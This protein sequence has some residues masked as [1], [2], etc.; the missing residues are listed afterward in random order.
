MIIVCGECKKQISDKATACPHCGA[1]VAAATLG[2]S[3]QTIERTAKRLKLNTLLSAI[4]CV[5]GII[6]MA[7]GDSRADSAAGPIGLLVLFVG[8]IWFVVTRIRIWW[9][10]G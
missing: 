5:V 8:L 2:T 6:I 9:N 1:P 3:V 10:H 4:C 7:N